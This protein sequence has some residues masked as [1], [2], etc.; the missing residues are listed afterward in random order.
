M[1]YY[2]STKFESNPSRV[3]LGHCVD[4]VWNDPIAEDIQIKDFAAKFDTEE[5]KK[6][7]LTL[8]NSYR[9]RKKML[10]GFNA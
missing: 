10:L 2:H 3:W 5:G 7:S 9:K 1:E 8:Q 4:L 6:R